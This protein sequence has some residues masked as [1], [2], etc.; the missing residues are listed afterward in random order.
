M[1][2]VDGKR[3]PSFFQEDTGEG[4][5]GFF[6]AYR[7]LSNFHLSPIVYEGILYPTSEHAYMACKVKDV[8][9][10]IRL[11]EITKPSEVRKEGRKVK[12]IPDWD[13]KRNQYM[14]EVLVCK[15]GQNPELLKRL[16]AT[17]D[18]YL[19]ETNDWGDEYWGVTLSRRGE[20][21]GQNNLGQILMTIREEAKIVMKWIDLGRILSQ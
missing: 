17:G 5:Y 16:L 11:S 18:K 9:E 1:I 4:I 12:L 6:D 15:F 19:E 8:S 20:R 7:F 13:N 14:Y 10:K 2:Y 21:T 3:L